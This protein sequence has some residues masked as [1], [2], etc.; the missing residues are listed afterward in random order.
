MRDTLEVLSDHLFIKSQSQPHISVYSFL[1]LEHK[2][3][4]SQSGTTVA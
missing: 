1:K 3:T 4:I 2:I